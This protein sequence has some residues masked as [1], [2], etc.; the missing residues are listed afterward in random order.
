[1]KL[2]MAMPYLRVTVMDALPEPRT[3]SGV[4]RSTRTNSLRIPRGCSRSS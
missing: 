4:P 2:P 1:M 3:V